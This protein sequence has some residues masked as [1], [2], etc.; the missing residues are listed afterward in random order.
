MPS[1][2]SFVAKRCTSL[3]WQFYHPWNVNHGH[4]QTPHYAQYK[5]KENWGSQIAYIYIQHFSQYQRVKILDFMKSFKIFRCWHIMQLHQKAVEF[6]VSSALEVPGLRLHLWNTLS[7]SVLMQ[8]DLGLNFRP[9]R[10]FYPPCAFR[11]DTS[12]MSIISTW[13]LPSLW[14][15]KS[16]TENHMETAWR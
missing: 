14:H 5:E 8:H 7:T 4:Q 13:P 15:R 10:N 16:Y 12:V 1:K 11:V 2:G 6:A 3:F 9:H